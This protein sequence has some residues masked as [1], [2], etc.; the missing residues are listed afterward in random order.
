MAKKVKTKK[1]I[2][3]SYSEHI[4]PYFMIWAITVLGQKFAYVRIQRQTFMFRR[5]T[6]RILSP[7]EVI[8]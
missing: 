8:I 3:N 4:L 7:V 1:F 2:E 6:S 5:N